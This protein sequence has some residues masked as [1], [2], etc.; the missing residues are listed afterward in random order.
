[1]AIHEL[2][3]GGPASAN[4]SR[5]M[6]PAPLFAAGSAPFATMRASAH[7]GPGVYKLSRVLD[8]QEDPALKQWVN[9]ATIAQGDDL[10]ILVIPQNMVL[11]GVHYQVERVAGV[12]MTLTPTLRVSTGAFPAINGNAL[13][14]ALTQAGVVGA[15]TA[16]GTAATI[17]PWY[18]ATP[19][20]Y[21]LDLTAW[22]AFGALRLAV[23]ALVVDTQPSD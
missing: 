8:F 6:F 1:M 12:A 21:S 11:L 15:I 19:E 22:T 2:Y 5:A 3:Q 14:T 4:S 7:K 9:N 20:M 23:T 10:G 16:T 18:I 13:A 17:V